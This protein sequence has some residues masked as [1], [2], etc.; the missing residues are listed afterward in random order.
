M[1][2]LLLL[3]ADA[4]CRLS[5]T[6]LMNDCYCHEV[7]RVEELDNVLNNP[8]TVSVEPVQRATQYG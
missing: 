2:Y 7:T 4:V 5:F 3:L 1:P 8:V 6:V